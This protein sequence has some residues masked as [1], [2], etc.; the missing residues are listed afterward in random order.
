MSLFSTTRSDEL[1]THQNG[2]IG[3]HGLSHYW[4]KSFD[5]VYRSSSRDAYFPYRGINMYDTYAPTLHYNNKFY[6][7]PAE[8]GSRNFASA[9]GAHLNNQFGMVADESKLELKTKIENK[10]V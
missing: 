10:K 9:I 3:G 1:D 4:Y 7:F 6:D 2:G 5:G 8:L